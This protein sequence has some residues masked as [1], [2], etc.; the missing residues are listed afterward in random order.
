MDQY[1]TWTT[2][3][4][5]REQCMLKVGGHTV[6]VELKECKAGGAQLRIRS[7]RDV[8]LYHAGQITK[9]DAEVCGE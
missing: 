8:E 1:T 4:K 5:L 3:L 6:L 2:R 9:E 7:N